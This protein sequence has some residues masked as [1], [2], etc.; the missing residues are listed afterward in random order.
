[1]SVRIWRNSDRNLSRKV[2]IPA[3]QHIWDFFSMSFLE[4]CNFPTF[5]SRRRESIETT[6]WWGFNIS[7]SGL[8]PGHSLIP[9]AFCK[10][11]LFFLIFRRAIV[12]FVSAGVLI[13]PFLSNSSAVDWKKCY[14]YIIDSVSQLGY[15]LTMILWI[16]PQEI[17]NHI[18]CFKPYTEFTS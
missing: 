8:S 18:Q 5:I 14:E 12:F 7:H 16:R 9:V 11:V 10:S 3:G 2:L 6:Y 1:M 17:I 15:N 4:Y 13:S